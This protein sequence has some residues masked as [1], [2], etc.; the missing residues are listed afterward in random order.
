MTVRRKES[1]YGGIDRSTILKPA[2]P[3]LNDAGKTFIAVPHLHSDSTSTSL[4]ARLRRTRRCL[5]TTARP[6]ERP[7]S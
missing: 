7:P 3:S 4:V 5:L 1:Q 2:V 6:L